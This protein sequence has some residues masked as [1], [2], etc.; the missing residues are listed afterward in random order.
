MTFPERS[1]IYREL[2]QILNR[3]RAVVY[4][5]HSYNSNLKEE[6]RYR[7]PSPPGTR[8][9]SCGGPLTRNSPHSGLA[10]G[11]S[12]SHYDTQILEE[13]RI[14]ENTSLIL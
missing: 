12:S 11:K 14:W 6:I 7:K 3:N 1:D 4:F 8:R 13:D 9:E 10:G 2:L 5:R